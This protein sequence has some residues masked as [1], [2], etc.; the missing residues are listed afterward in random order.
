MSLHVSVGNGE[1]QGPAR[2]A[3]GEKVLH[4]LQGQRLGRKGR[5]TRDRILAAA[6]KLINESEDLQV[7]LKAIAREAGIGMSALYNYFGDYADIIL[8][9][10]GKVSDEAEGAYLT[11]LARHWEDENLAEECDRFIQNFAA[12]W[13]RHANL[14]H[15]RNTLA[16]HRSQQIIDNRMS[17]S[18]E[19]G[20]AFV[21]QMGGRP[22]GEDS[23]AQG[24]ASALYIGIERVV[25]VLNNRDL[26][27]LHTSSFR[28]KSPHLLYAQARLLE[29]GIREMRASPAQTD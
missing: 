7:S 18:K 20:A 1:G 9:L 21:L 3:K 28:P 25:S 15:V 14:F 23:V 12:H 4:N 13:A 8:A 2:K 6:D 10:L 29:F 27:N 16:D 5:T 26:P 17:G 11:H 19:V 22:D 24:M